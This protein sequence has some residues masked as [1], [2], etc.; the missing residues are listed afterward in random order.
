MLQPIPLSAVTRDSSLRA[1]L[2]LPTCWNS[3]LLSFDK[4]PYQ[5]VARDRANKKTSHNHAHVVAA[6]LIDMQS[7]MSMMVAMNHR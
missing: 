1:V 6:A 7:M 2:N 3:P 4:I 5:Y